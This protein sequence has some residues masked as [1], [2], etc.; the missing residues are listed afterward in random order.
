M[1]NRKG[2]KII[3]AGYELWYPL[4]ERKKAKHGNGGV[5]GFF[6]GG[7]LSPGTNVNLRNTA[8]ADPPESWKGSARNEQDGHERE[9]E[10]LI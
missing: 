3:A 2:R 6:D 10:G 8:R 1:Y 7:L 4:P 9:N 5:P